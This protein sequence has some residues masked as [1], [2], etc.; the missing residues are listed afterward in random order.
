MDHVLPNPTT[1]ARRFGWASLLLVLVAVS[2]QFATALAEQLQ[3]DRGAL[4]SGQWWRLV[5]CHF[6]HWS[7]DHLFWDVLA[8]GVLAWISEKSNRRE[9][10]RCV[11]LSAVLIPLTLYWVVPGLP[12]YR[13]LSGIDSALFALVAT[14][15]LRQAVAERDWLRTSAA[16]L[17]AAGF[18]A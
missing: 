17:V 10:L 14:R 15:M 9:L 4:A 5:T 16:S 11:A 8:F 13:G 7:S 12:T 3:Y 1:P 18:A 2:L 6:V